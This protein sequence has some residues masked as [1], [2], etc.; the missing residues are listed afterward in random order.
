MA[1]WER[2]ASSPREPGRDGGARPRAWRAGSRRPARAVLPWHRRSE[3][4][5]PP[6]A[7]RGAA[8]WRG[9]LPGGG[10]PARGR[11]LPCSRP[12]SPL[13]LLN[14]SLGSWQFTLSDAK[15]TGRVKGFQVA[16]PHSGVTLRGVCPKAAVSPLSPSARDRQASHRPQ[17]SN[18][19]GL[20]P[21]FNA[22][23]QSIPDCK[24]GLS[25]KTSPWCPSSLFLQ[26]LSPAVH[27]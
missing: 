22:L 1:L 19:L 3:P 27:D 17:R 5:S 7:L 6:G 18:F 20:S 16:L 15:P 26:H 24:Y 13:T 8:C 23:C 9:V 10:V 14:A 2:R 4:V 21:C 25:L 12:R 11:E